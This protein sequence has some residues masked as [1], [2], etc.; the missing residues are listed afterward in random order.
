MLRRGTLRIALLV[1]FAI[2]LPAC[3]FVFTFADAGAPADGGSDEDAPNRLPDATALDAREAGA[4]DSGAQDGSHAHD[5]MGEGGCKTYAAAVTLF[6]NQ[7]NARALVYDDASLYWLVGDKDAGGS[8]MMGPKTGGVDASVLVADTGAYAT[9]LTVGDGVVYWAT[10]SDVSSIT[11]SGTMKSSVGSAPA[12]VTGL[13]AD[14]TGVYAVSESTGSFYVHRFSGGKATQLWTTSADDQG[15][16]IHID[17]THAYWVY[18]SSI[19]SVP[20]DSDGS[21]T[22]Y[23]VVGD[24]A[25]LALKGFAIDTASTYFA[26]YYVGSS[27]APGLYESPLTGGDAAVLDPASEDLEDPAVDDSSVYFWNGELSEI[28]VVPKGGGTV[29]KAYG[30][31]LGSGPT[32]DDQAIYFVYAPAGNDTI[33]RV[34]K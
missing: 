27:H 20:K 18:K 12:G 7:V 11:T 23:L 14:S 32:V 29:C 1:A 26:F 4:M 30:G 19:Y 3:E 33:M 15:E 16:P 6:P 8:V 5:A 10:G 24:G 34:T 9:A 22:P 17:L 2:P 25:K 28:Q 31:L 13:A 21:A